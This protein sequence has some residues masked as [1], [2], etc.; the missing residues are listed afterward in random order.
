M[1][2]MNATKLRVGPQWGFQ[3]FITTKEYLGQC[4]PSAVGYTVVGIYPK[5][6]LA[7]VDA[8]VTRKQKI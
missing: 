4:T 7:N 6:R 1:T 8:L 5:T 2:L 3:L